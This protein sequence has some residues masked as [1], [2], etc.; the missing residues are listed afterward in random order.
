MQRNAP[1]GDLVAKAASVAEDLA[2]AGW[3]ME[4]T[5]VAAGLEAVEMGVE[6]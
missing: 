1:E 3:V 6:D 2:A 4:E 5:A